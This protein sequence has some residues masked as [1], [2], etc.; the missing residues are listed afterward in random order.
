MS[1]GRPV[2]R[3]AFRAS[4]GDERLQVLLVLLLAL[5]VIAGWLL[6]RELAPAAYAGPPPTALE[7]AAP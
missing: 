4:D 2:A 1:G 6:I 3:P 5:C 7:A